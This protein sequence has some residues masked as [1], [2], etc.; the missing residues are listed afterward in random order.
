MQE[1]FT[2]QNGAIPKWLS[3]KIMN[4]CKYCGAPIV[5]SGPT[6]YSGK[7]QLTQRYCPNKYCPGHMGHKIV[8]LAEMFNVSGIGAETAIGMVLEHDLK[9]H[10]Q[11]LPIWFREKPLVHLWQVGK[12]AQIYGYDKQWQ[13]MLD[14][15]SSFEDYYNR[16]MYPDP[17]VSINY[18][19]LTWCQTF[20]NILPPLSANVINVMIS[21]SVEGYR[22][23]EDYIEFLNKHAG[24]FIQV[25]MVGKKKTGVDYL[26]KEPWSVDH[27]KTK[28]A[29]DAGIPIVSSQEFMAILI[30][31]VKQMMHKN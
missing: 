4:K 6:N 15:Y 5:D 18:D 27:D 1:V 28:T 2:K 29:L 26:I 22:R 3:D 7:M 20:F 12:A 19:Y 16:A 13:E 24:Q 10:I 25:R 30:V 31:L 17:V 23:K 11:V 9:Y 21:G 14:G 8:K